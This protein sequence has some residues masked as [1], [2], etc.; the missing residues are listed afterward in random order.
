MHTSFAV[1]MSLLDRIQIGSSFEKNVVCV[2]WFQTGVF[3]VRSHLTS[4]VSGVVD[5]MKQNIAHIVAECLCFAVGIA[6]H[7]G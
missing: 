1:I 4:V 6:E 3:E 7:C 2:Q 5:H